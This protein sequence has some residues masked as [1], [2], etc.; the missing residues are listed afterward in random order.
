MP[1]GLAQGLGECRYGQEQ[2]LAHRPLLSATSFV[3]VRR[4]DGTHRSA[5]KGSRWSLSSV[6]LHQGTEGPAPTDTGCLVQEEGKSQ[7]TSLHQS[8][9]NFSRGMTQPCC[10]Q[11]L[12]SLPLEFRVPHSPIIADIEAGHSLC[13]RASGAGGIEQHRPPTGCQDSPSGDN[14]RRPQTWPRVP[15]RVGGQAS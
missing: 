12:L 5:T 6:T 3:N 15:G 2:A 13:G 4:E 1:A 9:Q 7:P 14:H 11:T 8:L 10:V